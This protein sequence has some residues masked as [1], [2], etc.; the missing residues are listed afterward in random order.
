[1][2][3]LPAPLENARFENYIL[4]K[5]NKKIPLLNQPLKKLKGG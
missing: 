4:H 2:I 1:M 5:K 3:T